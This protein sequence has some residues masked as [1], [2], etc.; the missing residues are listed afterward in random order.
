VAAEYGISGAHV[1]NIKLR[2]R[3]AYVQATHV[4]T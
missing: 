3:R 4:P 2:K 1:T